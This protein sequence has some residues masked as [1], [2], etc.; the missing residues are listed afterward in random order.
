MIDSQEFFFVH[1]TR[2]FEPSVVGRTELERRYIHC[3]RWCDAADVA[4]LA[5][6]GETVYPL[7]LSELLADANAVASAAPEEPH[8]QLQFIR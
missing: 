4:D 8:R 7:Q 1:R 6:A 3:F 2:R 5:A